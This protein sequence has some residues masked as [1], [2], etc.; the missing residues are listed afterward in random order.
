MMLLSALLIVFAIGAVGSFWCRLR[1]GMLEGAAQREDHSH[2]QLT[3]RLSKYERVAKISAIGS[4]L[5]LMFA[6]VVGVLLK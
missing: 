2:A 5:A 1:I 6:I 3:A 4:A